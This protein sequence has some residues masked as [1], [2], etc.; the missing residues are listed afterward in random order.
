MAQYRITR[1]PGRST[2]PH[3]C[4]LC[5]DHIERGSWGSTYEDSDGDELAVCDECARAKPKARRDRI[6]IHIARLEHKAD[7]L[8]REMLPATFVVEA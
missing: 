1:Q 4:D 6:L 2:E 5:G 8:R 7:F 3:D